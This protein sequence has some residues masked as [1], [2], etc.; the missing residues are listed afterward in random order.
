MTGIEEK[1]RLKGLTQKEL[2]IKLN[3]DQTSISKWE[4]CVTKPRVDKLLAMAKILECTIDD[5]LKDTA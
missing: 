4:S 2:A 1:R 3:V 5:L